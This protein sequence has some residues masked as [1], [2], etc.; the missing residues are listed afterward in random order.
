MRITRKV[1]SIYSED[2]LISAIEERAFNEGYQAAKED[3]ERKKKLGTAA[4][5]GIGIAGTTAAVGGGLVAARKGFLG[6]KIQGKVGRA[7]EKLG[8]KLGM[9]SLVEKG[10]EANWNSA[11][12]EAERGKVAKIGKKIENGEPY[13]NYEK[14]VEELTELW[15]TRDQVAESIHNRHQGAG[16][17]MK[18]S[19]EKI[20]DNGKEIEANSKKI[21][22]ANDSIDE[23][24]S[25]KINANSEKINSNSKKIQENTNDSKL[26]EI[27]DI[28]GS[29]SL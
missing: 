16:E 3:E 2:K 4:K 21:K 19:L 8:E 7:Y 5:V 17:T 1:F 23:I 20:R 24:I 9:K 27:D 25:K 13:E 10:Q 28:L 6:H 18:K 22:E 11:V 29:L 12:T 14:D 26:D 15:K